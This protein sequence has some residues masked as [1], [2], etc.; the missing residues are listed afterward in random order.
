MLSDGLMEG[1][2]MN[3]AAAS[4]RSQRGFSMVELMVAMVVTLVV[5]GAIFGL[6]TA[7]GNAF[8]REPEVADRQ[9]NIRAAMDSIMRDIENAGGGMPLVAQV[10]THTDT[11]LTPPNATGATAP[12]LNGAGPQGVLGAAGQALRGAPPTGTLADLSDNS[13]ILEILIA[14]PACP[15]YRVCV[16][17]SVDG[18][19]ANLATREAI[20]AGGCLLSPGNVGSQGLV[21]LTDNRL[22]TIQPATLN[23]TG[24]GCG[25]TANGSMAV[26]AALAEWPTAGGAA[27]TPAGGASAMLYAARIVRYM[28][29]PGLDPMDA[30]PGLWRSDTGRYDAAGG[31]AA[32]P[33]AG[34]A[35]W[36]LVARGIEDLQLEYMN[37]QGAADLWSNNPGVVPACAVTGCVA[38]DYD[39]VV[40]RVRV[41]LSARALAPRLQ[42]ESA[43]AGGVAPNAVRG[44]LVSVMAPRAAVLGLQAVSPVS[45]W[46]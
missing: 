11:P 20:P 23:P 18:T 27:L 35:N 36:Q 30:S 42:G 43:P 12:Y 1:T 22:F 25:G 44:Q 31:L 14:E 3:I 19:P 41:T 38:A 5:S 39:R 15:V 34:A 7:G 28:I 33:A 4:N 9:Q 26:T 46:Q 32:V 24:G 40:R 45:T 13:D 21:L 17:A 10:F 16:P 8:R 2:A 6:L 29:A 37:G